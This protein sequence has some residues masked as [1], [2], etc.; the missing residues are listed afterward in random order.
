MTW[1]LWAAACGTS[2]PADE[3]SVSPGEAAE[4]LKADDA[5][6]PRAEIKLLVDPYD[7][8]Y[9]R[10]LVGLEREMA[11]E[12]EVYFY[13]TPG[14]EMNEQGLV[15]RARKIKDD[16]DD[17]TV[18]MRPM[19]ADE[20]DP[21]WFALEK[22][23]CE[24]DVSLAKVVSSCSFRVGQDAGE[25]DQVAAGERVID[26][27]FSSQQEAFAAEYG[28]EVPWDQLVPLGPSEA[29]VWKIEASSL[30]DVMTAELWQFPGEEL[31]ELS[32]K[33]PVDDSDR[34]LDDLLGW[35]AD[36][37]IGV[38]GVQGSKTLRALEAFAPPR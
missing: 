7:I 38:A 36:R 18:K 34:T 6:G 10:D 13:D 27:L 16:A 12:R 33:V 20:V 17:S 24:I 5:S 29:W 28:P 4:E 25:I 15:L 1:L 37:D 11:E 26:K 2:V 3:F 22:F 35:L 19:A 9:V 30:P 31:L 32:L 23:K 14:L 8:D 21:S